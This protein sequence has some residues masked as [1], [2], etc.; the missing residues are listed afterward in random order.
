MIQVDVN[1]REVC[2]HDVVSDYEINLLTL[3]DANL[4][5]AQE[6]CIIVSHCLEHSRL[7]G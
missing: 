1:I 4:P 2:V 5:F 6:A 3:M 7:P